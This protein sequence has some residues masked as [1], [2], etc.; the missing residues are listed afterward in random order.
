MQTAC[1]LLHCHLCTVLIYNT[2]NIASKKQIFRKKIYWTQKCV[3]ISSTNFIWN[4]LIL[5]RIQWDIVINVET[6]SCNVPVILVR[7]YWNLSHFDRFRIKLKY[8]ISPTS[9]R[10]EPTCYMQKD[11]QTDV[12]KLTVAFINFAKT[13]KIIPPAHHRLYSSSHKF[14]CNTYAMKRC[15]CTSRSSVILNKQKAIFVYVFP[16]CMLRY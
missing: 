12:A 10:C 7:F 9:I 14:G 4:I 16:Q 1:A 3:L 11:R 5:R 2:F 13:P 6:S 15:A 8:Q